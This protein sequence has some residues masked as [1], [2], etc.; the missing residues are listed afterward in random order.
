MIETKKKL[1]D[2][3]H[4]KSVIAALW[5]NRTDAQVELAMTHPVRASP[6]ALAR[7][8]TSAKWFL[9]ET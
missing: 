2:T 1:S 4:Q 7:R 3:T 9:L 5:A 6:I 8:V